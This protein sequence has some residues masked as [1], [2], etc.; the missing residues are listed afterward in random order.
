M[1]YVLCPVPV[2]WHAALAAL[3][4]CTAKLGAE[5][6][7]ELRAAIQG[8]HFGSPCR[9]RGSC[10]NRWRC[11]GGS[12]AVTE[13][14]PA[15]HL[16]SSH[17]CCPNVRRPRL[18]GPAETPV[19]RNPGSVA[20]PSQGAVH[21]TRPRCDIAPRSRRVLSWRDAAGDGIGAGTLMGAERRLTRTMELHHVNEVL[22]EVLACVILAYHLSQANVFFFYLLLLLPLI[23]LFEEPIGM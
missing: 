7:A 8:K 2:P 23:F 14:L 20:A 3:A 15:R 5:P 16:P 22:L 10:P 12:H 18:W 4:A 11:H 19:P 6:T 21:P 17:R 9:P 1:S 13:W